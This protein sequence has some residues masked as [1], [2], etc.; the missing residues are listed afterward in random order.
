MDSLE[1][2]AEAMAHQAR[3][4]HPDQPHQPL[5]VG[6]G[7]D[8]V[9]A[10]EAV[11]AAVSRVHIPS[12]AGD[13][14]SRALSKV[15]AENRRSPPGAKTLAVVDGP[16]GIGKS[17]LVRHWACLYYVRAVQKA[18][19]GAAGLPS[20]QTKTMEADLLP[21]WWVNLKAKSTIKDLDSAALNFIGLP[22]RGLQRD[23]TRNLVAA[24]GRHR[25]RVLVLDDIHM[26]YT[27]WAGGRAVLDHIKHL[28]TE[29]GEKGVTLV[30]VG[31]D[32]AG[33]RIVEDP[34]IATRTRSIRL[35][36]VSA[37]TQTGRLQWQRQLAPLEEAVLPFLPRAQPGL[38]TSRWSGLIWLRT[39]GFP[40]DLR[41]LIGQAAALALAD[42]RATIS[43]DDL[44]G[45]PLSPRAERAERDLA[46][47]GARR[48][49]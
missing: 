47:K 42:G 49:P 2:H 17:T 48:D 29:L 5:G 11:L 25:T 39:Q 35:D 7:P 20:Y 33:G 15:V 32:L 41:H 14:A 9:P 43:E 18:P 27:D 26:L 12:A 8:D 21:V 4:D 37:L 44:R 38:L 24:A 6:D 19:I 30:L 28:N 13:L 3:L 10:E 31:A 45:V 36:P 1:F 16:F 23:L 46:A 22:T 34:Q 40:A